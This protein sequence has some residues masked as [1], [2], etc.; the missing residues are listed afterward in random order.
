MEGKDENFPF[1]KFMQ[2]YLRRVRKRE[3][4]RETSENVI[5]DRTFENI[6]LFVGKR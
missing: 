1:P 6:H 2:Q 4:N 5:I 3:I